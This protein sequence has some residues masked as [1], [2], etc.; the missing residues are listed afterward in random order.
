MKQFIRIFALAFVFAA[1]FVA[2][3]PTRNTTVASNV[4]SFLPPGPVPTCN[5]F[6]QVCPV[7]R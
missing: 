2:N 3:S 7:I 6:T 5:P 4:H 1:A